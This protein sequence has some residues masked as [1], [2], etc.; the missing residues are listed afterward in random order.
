MLELRMSS[1]LVTPTEIECLDVM[2][3]RMKSAFESSVDLAPRSS[4][5]VH[6]NLEACCLRPTAEDELPFR[7]AA[8]NIS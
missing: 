4:L 6:N 7:E 8:T 2:A 5:T 1:Q 3:I